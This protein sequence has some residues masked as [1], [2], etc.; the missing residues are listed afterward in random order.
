M[1][2]LFVKS[3]VGLIAG[4]AV[5]LGVSPLNGPVF[6]QSSP[7]PTPPAQKV[8]SA[9][10]PPPAKCPV[11]FFRDLLAM[12]PAER[13]RFLTNRPAASQKLLLAKLHE[14]DA[15]KPEQ[16]DLRLQATELRWY[17]LPL[18]SMPPSDRAAQLTNVPVKIRELITDRLQVWDSL[19]ADA[20]KRLLHPAADYLSKP[21]VQPASLRP[22][23][24]PA[25]PPERQAHLE[26]GIRDWQN[27]TEAEREDIVEHFNEWFELSA[28]EQAK[29]LTGISEPERVQMEKTFEKFRNLSSAQRGACLRS[30]QKFASMSLA[31]R[32]QFLENVERWKQMTPSERQTWKDLV[33]NLGSQPPLPPGLGSPPMPPRAPRT[34]PVPG[35]ATN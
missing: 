24:P 12:E 35:V 17:L 11:D 33:Y 9:I 18:M 25:L 27:K 21:P 13:V 2:S 22:P 1:N 34:P 30:F 19:P 32:Q 7:V 31:E 3:S 14:Y 20:Q 23:M 16:R 6:A 29:T 5:W 15:L 26:A 8:P 4:A 28:R 10:L